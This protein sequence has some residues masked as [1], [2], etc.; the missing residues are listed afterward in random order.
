MAKKPV[1][2]SPKH[3]PRKHIDCSNWPVNPLRK[4]LPCWLYVSISFPEK[5][6]MCGPS[7]RAQR[8]TSFPYC[9]VSPPPAPL[10]WHLMSRS[11][12]CEAD[13][14]QSFTRDHCFVVDFVGGRGGE[15]VFLQVLIVGSCHYYDS[16][17]A[18]FDNGSVSSLSSSSSSSSS[19]S[20]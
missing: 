14:C 15:P 17:F 1:L 4:P 6:A 5:R 11:Q 16:N 7:W 2:L 19:S 3:G 12:V 9:V 10:N 18:F 8:L 20:G 13:L